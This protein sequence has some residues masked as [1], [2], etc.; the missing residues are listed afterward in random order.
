LN[1]AFVIRRELAKNSPASSAIDRTLKTSIDTTL[2][3]CLKAVGIKVLHSRKNV[4]SRVKRNV[5]RKLLSRSKRPTIDGWRLDD[6]EFDELHNIYK[7]TVEG[8]CHSL[9]LNGHRGLPFYSKENYLLSHDVTGQ[10]IYCNPPW[11]L[12]CGTSA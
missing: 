6:R 5:K 1:D 3:T 4:E 8:C 9:G 10:S 11:S 2:S 7:F 12:V